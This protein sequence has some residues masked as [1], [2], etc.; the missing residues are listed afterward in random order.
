[1]SLATNLHDNFKNV[2]KRGHAVSSKEVICVGSEIAII[3]GGLAIR[4]LAGGHIK[5]IS[6]INR[7]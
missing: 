6:E 5:D 7:H 3:K 1:M 4:L 2:T